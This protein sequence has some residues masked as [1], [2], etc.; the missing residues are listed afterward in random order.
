MA[1]ILDNHMVSQRRG[2]WLVRPPP[3]SPETVN[4]GSGVFKSPTYEEDGRLLHI[5]ICGRERP[6]TYNI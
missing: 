3:T 2:P 6:A 5:M 4:T 1:T